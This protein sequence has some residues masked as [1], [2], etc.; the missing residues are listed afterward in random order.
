[1]SDVA[2]LLRA[3]LSEVSTKSDDLV[4]RWIDVYFHM[5]RS[6]GVE[7]YRHQP[8]L[9]VDLILRK[10]EDDSCI[11]MRDPAASQQVDMLLTL[12]HALSRMWVLSM[13]E[14]I[15]LAQE[16]DGGRKHAKLTAL[17]RRIEI[18]RVPIAKQQIANDQK[19][20]G[21]ITL[22]PLGAEDP[23]QIYSA[24]D[25][26]RYNPPVVWDKATGSAAWLVLDS[27]TGETTDISR[28]ALS[29]ETLALF[30]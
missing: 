18:V 3:I 13:Y 2:S 30:S 14:G 11:R 22:V 26:S 8:D 9:W 10:M 4:E 28:R 19:I 21:S 7:S 25:R 20:K 16:T 1:M 29:D 27:R 15:R 17:R 24:K 12:Q 23:K 6:F 5:A